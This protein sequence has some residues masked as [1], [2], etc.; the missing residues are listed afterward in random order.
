MNLHKKEDRDRRTYDNENKGDLSKQHQTDKVKYL[1]EVEDVLKYSCGKG[2]AFCEKV[3]EQVRSP[4]DYWEFLKSHHIYRTEVLTRNELQSLVAELL[5][6][7]PDLVEGF[8]ELLERYELVDTYS[9]GFDFCEEVKGRLQSPADYQTFVKYL[10]I[11]SREVITREQLQSLVAHTLGRYP[12]LME[13]LNKFIER[14][15]RAVGYLVGVMTKSNDGHTNSK[16]KEEKKDSEQ[17]CKTEA[18]PQ[19]TKSEEAVRFVEKVKERFQNTGHVYISFLDILK[20]YGEEQKNSY[21]VYHE[22]IVLF[23]DHLDLVDEF[24]KFLSDS[25]TNFK[26]R[27][28]ID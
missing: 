19:K 7:Y 15:D 5:G 27:K 28:S 16:V 20:M 12:D 26:V 9:K 13:G 1:S 21:E 11:Y 8:N 2:F 6:K 17:A 4:A 10:H 18:A 25:S 22:V 23:K 24:T 3:K 14:Y